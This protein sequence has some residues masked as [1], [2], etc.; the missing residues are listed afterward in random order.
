[1]PRDPLLLPKQGQRLGEQVKTVTSMVESR[2]RAWKVGRRAA[3]TIGRPSSAALRCKPRSFLASQL[4]L[5]PMPHPCLVTAA[6][7]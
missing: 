1:M 7:L 6:L 3:H 5:D 4:A 2:R